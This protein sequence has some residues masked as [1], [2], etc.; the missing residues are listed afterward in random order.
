MKRLDL[1][2]HPALSMVLLLLWL[3]LGNGTSAAWIL[4][5]VLL[6]IALP[7]ACRRFCQHMPRMRRAY[8][9]F[10]LLLIVLGDIVRANLQVARLILGPVANM[11]PAFIEVP[12]DVH[13]P[14]VATLLG[15]IVTLTPGTVAID[16]DE[17]S[18]VLQ[19]HALNVADGDA[20]IRSIK[21]RYEA[22]LKEIFAC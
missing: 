3:A 7:L 2:P 12:L 8:T 14:F 5:G 21:T 22:R 4:L 6:A 11:Q 9:A 18:W 15:S 17:Q 1:L 20:L 16:V 19:V 10:E 13:D